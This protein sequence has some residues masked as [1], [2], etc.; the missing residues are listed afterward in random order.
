VSQVVNEMRISTARLDEISTA[1]KEYETCQEFLK[2]TKEGF[3]DTKD[4]LPLEVR[5][6]W[7]VRND[8]KAEG[9]LMYRAR[10]VI[11]KNMRHRILACLHEGHMGIV[12]TK[13][14]ARATIYW[15]G[16]S[17][18][19]EDLVKRCNTCICNNPIRKEPL[20]LKNIIRAGMADNMHG[21][22]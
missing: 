13:L 21:H 2:F 11:P 1:Q 4:N 7:A 19:I 9:L 10:I 12:K 17:K 14:H 6:F 22:C 20:I 16:L 8:L 18:K 15:P 3:P 5:E